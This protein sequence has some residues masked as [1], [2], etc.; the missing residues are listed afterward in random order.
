MRYY[1]SRGNYQIVTSHRG[2]VDIVKDELLTEHEV[3]EIGITPYPR[4]FKRVKVWR[5]RTYHS[6]SHRF[7]DEKYIR[8]VGL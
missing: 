5:A 7:A 2:F 3:Q 8:G 6:F 1:M 4:Y